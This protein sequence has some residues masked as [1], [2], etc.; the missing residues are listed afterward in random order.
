MALPTQPVWN[1]SHELE[2][3]PGSPDWNFQAGREQVT[4]VWQ[5][6][7]ES[8]LAARPPMNQAMSGTP[9]DLLVS[10]ARVVHMEG[11]K[12]ELTVTLSKEGRGDSEEEEEPYQ[13]K[14]EVEW[15]RVEKKLES[16][17]YFRDLT[18]SDLDK[19]R[20][21]EG[22]DKASERATAYA[23]LSSLAKELADKKARG[24][25]TYLIYT[26]I[27]RRTMLVN[28]MPTVTP[29]GVRENPPAGCK[30][31]SGYDYLKTACRGTKTGTFGRWELIEEW[32]GVDE[33][34][35]DIY[36]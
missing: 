28:N 7:Y 6:P 27:A 23:A 14:Y 32:T 2:E 5:G 25:D 8:C 11:G 4:R 36:E 17:T 21:W 30:A 33:W 15:L 12:G 3:Q 19:L 31:P 9:A 22:K 29:C 16:H 34:D 24:Q 1:G 20:E 26:P 10:N 35:P 13:A 18:T